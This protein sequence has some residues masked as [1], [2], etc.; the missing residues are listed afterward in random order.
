M[1]TADSFNVSMF[2]LKL[3]SAAFRLVSFLISLE[4]TYSCYVSLPLVRNVVSCCR[5]VICCQNFSVS[6]YL[7]NQNSLLHLVVFQVTALKNLNSAEHAKDVLALSVTV[8]VPKAGSMGS[9]PPS[10]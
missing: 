10:V 8:I 7:F 2:N 4:I 6:I 5:P 3:S 1:K 9:K